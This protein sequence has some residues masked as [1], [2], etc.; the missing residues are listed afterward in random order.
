MEKQTNATSNIN[1]KHEIIPRTNSQNISK[2]IDNSYIDYIDNSMSAL[3]R[4]SERPLVD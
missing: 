1:S 3:Q 4:S 2:V